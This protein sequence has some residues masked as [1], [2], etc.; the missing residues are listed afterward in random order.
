[1]LDLDYNATTPIKP[2]VAEAME[3]FL[4]DAYGNPSSLH[5][6]GQRTKAAVEDARQ[7]LARGLG[8]GTEELVLTASGSEANSF[9]IRGYLG[10]PEEDHRILTTSV[11]HSSV[12]DTVRWYGDHGATVEHIPLGSGGQLDLAAFERMLDPDVDLV[13]TMWVNNETGIVHPVEDVGT[14]CREAGVPLHVDAVQAFGKQPLAFDDMPVDMLT[15]SAHKI[16]GPKGIGALLAPRN[17]ELD[18]LIFGGHQERERRGGTENVPAIVGF[19]EAVRSLDP[20]GWSGVRT[21]RNQFERHMQERWNAVVTGEGIDRVANTSGLVLPGIDGGD[22]VRMLDMR[23][24]GIATGSACTSGTPQPSH[25]VQS[26][27]LPE[28]VSPEG[29]IRVSFPPETTDDVRAK[30]TGTLDEVCERL[31][32]ADSRPTEPEEQFSPVPDS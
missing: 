20:D 21:L 2:A 3:P 22:V 8:T 26:L 27:D 7:S 10:P 31:H 24:I 17:W 12:R 1:M 6:I 30:L 15:V 28:H 29:F 13:S 5:R 23:G 11:E 25:V 14:R 16:G 18:P 32:S 19:A 9:A 4:R